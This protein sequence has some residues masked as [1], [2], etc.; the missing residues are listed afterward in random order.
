[1]LVQIVKGA[2]PIVPP[3]KAVSV[4]ST[5]ADRTII[6]SEKR[7]ASRKS[8]PLDTLGRIHADRHSPNNG[9]SP[10]LIA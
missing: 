9:S 1:M 6:L 4:N 3:C 8:S 5:R 10:G 7:S 2:G